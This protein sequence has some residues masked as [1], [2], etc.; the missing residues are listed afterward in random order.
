MQQKT[1]KKHYIKYPHFLYT[2][3]GRYIQ[4]GIGY[5]YNVVKILKAKTI[6]S[7]GV[8][9]YGIL[10][11]SQSPVITSVLVRSKCMTIY[12]ITS[13]DQ[14]IYIHMYQQI[15]VYITRRL[16]YRS[17]FKNIII[18]SQTLL[19]MLVCKTIDAFHK[20]PQLYYTL[21]R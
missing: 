9:G 2:G 19:I 12:T 13:A 7:E 14:C 15:F 5:H 16:I 3:R 20:S 4:L 6:W 1:Q 17:F 11:C 21:L 10:S 8:G 18:I